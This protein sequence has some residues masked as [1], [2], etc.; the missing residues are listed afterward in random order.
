M[1]NVTPVETNESASSFIM[2]Q[3]QWINVLLN[4]ICDYWFTAAFV[5]THLKVPYMESGSF[6]N[7]L[8]SFLPLLHRT[9]CSATWDTT[10]VTWS[11]HRKLWKTFS[12]L[13]VV[14]SVHGND[15]SFYWHVLRDVLD[16]CAISEIQQKQT[17]PKKWWL[18][19]SI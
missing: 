3:L 19:F 12:H 5:F 4:N 9:V 16:L 17:F 13:A 15:F 6:Y 18:Q 8:I 1:N 2:M 7:T 14:V 10:E 11:I